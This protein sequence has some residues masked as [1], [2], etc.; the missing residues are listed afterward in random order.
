MDSDGVQMDFFRVA[1]A[2]VLDPEALGQI[3]ILC[4]RILVFLKVCFIKGEL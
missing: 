1:D 3:M 4:C 2:K